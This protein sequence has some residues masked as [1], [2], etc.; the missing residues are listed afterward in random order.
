MPELESSRTAGRAVQTFRLSVL[1]TILS[2]RTDELT[3][4]A[5]LTARAGWKALRSLS[6]RVAGASRNWRGP[7][8][9]EEAIF[10]KNS[11]ILISQCI[12]QPAIDLSE[13]K[14]SEFCHP[15]ISLR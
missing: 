14:R 10:T 1:K 12:L 4:F 9:Q 2:G 5:S 3:L 8:V 13:C 15:E 11:H 7:K 6:S